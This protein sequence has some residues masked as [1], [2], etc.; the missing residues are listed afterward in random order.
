MS[1]MQ[2]ISPLILMASVAFVSTP[3]MSQSGGDDGREW[4]QARARLMQGH[5]MAVHQSIDRWK[6]LVASDRLSFS[7][8]AGFLLVYPGYPQ[9]EKIRRFA[10]QAALRESPDARSVVEIGRASCRDRVGTYV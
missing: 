1:S 4:D 3:A 2:R 7:T 10:E 9:E 6:Q 8:Y 5:E